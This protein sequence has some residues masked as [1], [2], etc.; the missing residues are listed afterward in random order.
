VNAAYLPG[1]V[2][3]EYVRD[4]VLDI[5]FND[6]T[7]KLVDVSQWF[8]GPVFEPLKKKA[9][10][11]RFFVEGMTV[12]WPNGVDIAPEALYAANDLGPRQAASSRPPRAKASRR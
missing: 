1:V 6:G 3:A 7:Q 11:K 8:R 2:R 4:Y 12:G 5:T 10:F 9:Y